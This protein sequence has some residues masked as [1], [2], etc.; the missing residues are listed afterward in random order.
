MTDRL[1]FHGNFDFATLRDELVNWEID[2]FSP[3][4]SKGFLEFALPDYN[5]KAQVYETGT[6]LISFKPW[7]RETQLDVLNVLTMLLDPLEPSSLK[8]VFK[9]YIP[10]PKAK[11]KM[12]DA[13]FNLLVKK[14]VGETPSARLKGKTKQDI[15]QE[16]CK[17]IREEQV[18]DRH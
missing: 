13:A 12:F 18:G 1:K 8:L 11:E 17:E 5:V 15:E 3:E 14:K 6:L 4:T 9:K 16:V 2:D 7:T 10:G